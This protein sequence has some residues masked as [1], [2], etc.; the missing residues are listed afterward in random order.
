MSD[1]L[2]AA[3]EVCD[4]MIRRFA[5]ESLPPAKHFHYHQGVFLSGM[6][7][8]YL[9]TLD[10]RYYDYIKSWI[11]SMIDPY[12]NITQF[13]PGQLDDL[14]PGILLFPLYERERDER[15]RIAMDTI[16]YYI[17]HFA[18]NPDDGFWHKAWYRNQMWLDGLYMGGVFSAMYAR[19]F[20]ANDLLDLAV[21]QARE[22]ERRTRDESTGL[23]YHAYDYDK[24][25]PWA[26]RETGRSP[27]FWGR[28]MG[29]VTVALLDEMECAP[30]GHPG[31]ESLR[32]IAVDLLRGIARYQDRESGLW[33]QVVDKG[34]EPGNWLESSCTCLFAAS[35]F[36]AVKMGLL[37]DGY[38][39]QARAACEGVTARLYYDDN[40]LVIDNIC[41]GTGVG[42]YNH[43]V[44][45]PTSRNDLHGVGAFLLMCAAAY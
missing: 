3:R 37:D 1:S 10:E 26:D 16:A 32:R 2:T 18:K 36:R 7:K 12:G 20:G 14:Q 19:T 5:P 28:A 11:D 29:W 24:R 23:W 33:Y 17:R 27:E 41:V 39:G 43:Y 45:R 25:Q 42:D 38:L 22:M 34:G 40:G 44:N 35:L 9:L 4:T 31:M 30:D 13:N 21:F 15:Y 8:T 6:F